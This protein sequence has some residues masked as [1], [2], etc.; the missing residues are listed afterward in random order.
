MSAVHRRSISADRPISAH[1]ERS[2]S[3]AAANAAAGN[4]TDTDA[5]MDCQ[6]AVARSFVTDTSCAFGPL[7]PPS[8]SGELPAKSPTEAS[9]GSAPEQGLCMGQA[10]K[11]KVSAHFGGKTKRHRSAEAEEPVPVHVSPH[12]LL[13]GL[14]G[15]LHPRPC[16]TSSADDS[17]SVDLDTPEEAADSGHQQQEDVSGAARGGAQQNDME[18]HIEAISGLEHVQ[19]FA[20]IAN[21]AVDSIAKA[22]SLRRFGMAEPQKSTKHRHAGTVLQPFAPP[23]RCKAS[24]DK[25]RHAAECTPV[26]NG[27]SVAPALQKFAC[28]V[29]PS[30]RSQT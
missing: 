9:R 20:S 22:A 8:V 12:G 23:R 2:T 1:L 17:I 4:R 15:R 18:P 21:V 19:P 10:S 11:R 6:P 14:V 3:S 13:G 25:Q 7:R 27:G 30:E 29:G 28:L 5:E 24:Q 16:D 26:E